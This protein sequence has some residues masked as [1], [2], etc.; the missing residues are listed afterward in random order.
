[1]PTIVLGN[2]SLNI[3]LDLANTKIGILPLISKSGLGRQIL[4]PTPP[5]TA[6]RFVHLFSVVGRVYVLK[7][8]RQTFFPYL[9]SRCHSKWPLSLSRSFLVLSLALSLPALVPNGFSIPVYGE[10]RERIAV[11]K[12]P[13]CGI[14]DIIIIQ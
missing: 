3:K 6:S 13:I 7:R 8:G 2:F 10:G 4:P 12:V 1:M 14:S 9:R 11:E 5:T